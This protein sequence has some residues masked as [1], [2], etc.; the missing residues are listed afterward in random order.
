[1]E[2]ISTFKTGIYGG[3][4]LAECGDRCAVRTEAGGEVKVRKLSRN[5][6]DVRAQQGQ[7]MSAVAASV[8][9]MGLS[10]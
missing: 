8:A 9:F 2:T 5:Q 7:R 4:S 3:R 6:W 10:R 1:M